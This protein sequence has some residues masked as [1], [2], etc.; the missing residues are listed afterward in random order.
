MIIK[1]FTT[2]VSGSKCIVFTLV[3]MYSEVTAKRRPCFATLRCAL[4]YI[5]LSGERILETFH[6]ASGNGGS[7]R[8]FSGT[9]S[10]VIF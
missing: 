3:R 5:V 9:L 7:S 4:Q 10:V 8:R 1:C 6:V 2:Q